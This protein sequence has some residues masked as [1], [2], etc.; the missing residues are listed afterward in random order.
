MQELIT[1]KLLFILNR[2]TAV[3]G[4]QAPETLLQAMLDARPR[5]ED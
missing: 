2:R 4:A 5:E 3:S 1:D